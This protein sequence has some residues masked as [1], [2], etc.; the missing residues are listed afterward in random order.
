MRRNFSVW[1]FVFG[2]G[3]LIICRDFC[4]SLHACLL[5]IELFDIAALFP[6]SWAVLWKLV[7]CLMPWVWLG[8]FSSQFNSNLL[9]YLACAPEG[10]CNCSCFSAS[11]SWHLL[12]LGFCWLFLFLD[13]AFVL[14]TP[15]LL[16]S[17]RSER[18]VETAPIKLSWLVRPWGS[19][20]VVDS[21]ANPFLS[22]PPGQQCLLR[23]LKMC[24]VWLNC[25]ECSF[26]Y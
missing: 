20:Q 15:M 26:M 6:D 25:E 19:K 5:A 11:I 16:M 23:T 2:V 8:F 17:G 1:F 12:T 10:Q 7:T 4:L 9:D 13:G 14:T 22:W 18:S 24:I 3:F 21:K